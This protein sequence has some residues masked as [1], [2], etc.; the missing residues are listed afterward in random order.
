LRGKD[1]ASV[2]LTKMLP[3]AMACDL[4][5][6]GLCSHTQLTAADVGAT[7][8]LD[9]HQNVAHAATKEP[10]MGWME[11]YYRLHV[12][13]FAKMVAAFKSVP[14][15]SGTMLDNSILVLSTEIAN[16]GHDLYRMMYV[17]AGGKNLGLKPGRYIKYAETGPNPYNLLKTSP[18]GDRPGGNYGSTTF[19]LGPSHSRLLVSLMQAFGVR[20]SSIGLEAAVGTGFMRDVKIEMTGPLPRLKG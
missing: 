4:T 3:T 16:G 8:G 18:Y 15:G 17:I 19:G 6:V 5:R 13:Q 1:V 20:R 7:A 14:E 9:V 10:G 11:N 2:I 12:G